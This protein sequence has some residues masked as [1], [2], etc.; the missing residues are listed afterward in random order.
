[1]LRID[2]I[3]FNVSVE[4][5]IKDLKEYINNYNISEEYNNYLDGLVKFFE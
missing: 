4:N 2:D 5:L 3:F 1:M